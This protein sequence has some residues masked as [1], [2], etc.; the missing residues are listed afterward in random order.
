[1]KQV[2][3]GPY[4]DQYE[5]AVVPIG[6]ELE[7]DPRKGDKYVFFKNACYADNGTTEQSILQGETIY[8][9]TRAA[10]AMYEGTNNISLA[11]IKLVAGIAMGTIE[12]G[13]WGVAQIKGPSDFVRTDAGVAVGD[14][15]VGDTNDGE[16]DTLAA[17][18]EH[19]VFGFA[20]KDDV[21]ITDDNG[22]DLD[23]CE[24]VLTNCLWG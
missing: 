23:G 11:D 6:T 21:T 15:L 17:G 14:A 13:K 9:C 10:N 24:A 22:D 8:Q 5:S 19:L 20:Q 1:M 3:P 12:F 7:G 4:E 16:A 2:F 18:A